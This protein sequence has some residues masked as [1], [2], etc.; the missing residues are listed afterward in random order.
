MISDDESSS[1]IE[2]EAKPL[3]SSL[4]VTADAEI[5]RIEVK[6]RA[7]KPQLRFDEE[8]EIALLKQASARSPW[9]APHG[10]NQTARDNL[11]SSGLIIDG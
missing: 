5:M 11:L 3:P 1:E 8:S 7:I 6:N 9:R 4:G 10:I 2:A